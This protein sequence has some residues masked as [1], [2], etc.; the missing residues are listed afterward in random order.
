MRR[1]AR[2]LFQPAQEF[3]QGAGVGAQGLALH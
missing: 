3:H 2:R 1:A